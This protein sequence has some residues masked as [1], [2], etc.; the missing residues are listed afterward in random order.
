M[1][2]VHLK[3]AKQG[4]DQQRVCVVAVQAATQAEAERLSGQLQDTIVAAEVGCAKVLL[5]D[6]L[7]TKAEK[8]VRLGL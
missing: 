7:S 5:Y 3:E 6:E 8:L 1:C 2:S 4:K